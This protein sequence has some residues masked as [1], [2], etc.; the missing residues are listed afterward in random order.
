MERLTLA[1]P[2]TREEIIEAVE[3]KRKGVWRD[4]TWTFFETV[5]GTKRSRI[6]VTK[7]MRVRLGISYNKMKAVI[8]RKAKEDEDA[9]GKLA[10]RKSSYTH[11][12]LHGFIVYDRTT[13]T[14]EFLQVFVSNAMRVYYE[15]DAEGNKVR[16]FKRCGVTTR[17]FKDGLE[18][19]PADETLLKTVKA[20][21]PSR[22]KSSDEDEAFDTFVLPLGKILKIN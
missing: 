9:G 7:T 20:I 13:V 12:K 2:L 11:D 4:V 6:V 17:Y 1:T 19:D 3:K 21:T 14:K 5:L 22:A 18:I 8:E 10:R 16:R 15:T